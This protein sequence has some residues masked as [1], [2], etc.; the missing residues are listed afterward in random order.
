MP[1]VEEIREDL[2]KRA[3]EVPKY[4]FVLVDEWEDSTYWGELGMSLRQF[5]RKCRQLNLF[6]MLIIPN[7]FQLPLSYA[8]S[9]SAFAIDV[10]FEDGF[11][12]G[13]FDFYDF[14]SKRYLYIKGKKYHHY[15]V[16]RPTFQGRFT[17]GYGLPEKEYRKAKYQDMMEYDAQEKKKPTEYEI[18]VKMFQQIKDK[19]K[20]KVPNFT[21]KDF[22]DSFSVSERTIIR[23]NK[24]DYRDYS[25]PVI[26]DKDPTTP[27]SNNFKCKEVFMDE[28]GIEKDAKK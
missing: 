15:K 12:R 3:F 23:W 18:K 10:K 26:G 2:I 5:F 27:Y 9:R 16:Q 1:R 19:I 28:E 22:A 7:W 20:E 17:D 14:E 4:S 21:N 13:F 6:M 8:V 11:Q 24:N 25:L